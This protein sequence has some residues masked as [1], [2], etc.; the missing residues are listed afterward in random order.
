MKKTHIDKII[1]DQ[2]IWKKGNE[3]LYDL[4]NKYPNNNKPD[5]IVAKIWILGRTYSAAIERRKNHSKLSN[6]EFYKQK[7]PNSIIKVKLDSKL[8]EIRKTS[9]R[10]LKIDLLLSTHKQLQSSI[11]EITNQNKRSLCSKY[12]HFH[13]PSDYYIYDTRAVK[14]L[15]KL[16]STLPIPYKHRMNLIGNK[17]DSEYANHYLKSNYVK[18][19]LENISGRNISNREFD[20]ILLYESTRNKNET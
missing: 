12:L 9:D 5:E 17:W 20:S 7:V 18:S 3:W 11:Q 8:K 19:Y 14:G 10:K 1:K 2:S 6:D 4:F 15:S 16:N 13:L